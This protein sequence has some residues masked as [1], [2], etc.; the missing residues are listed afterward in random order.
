MPTIRIQGEEQ[1]LTVASDANLWRSLIAGG[2]AV[3]AP[4]G[5]RGTCGKCLVQVL[6][7]ELPAGEH[8]RRHLS[9]AQ[10]ADGWRLSCTARVHSDCTVAVPA[11]S[12]QEEIVAA[13]ADAWGPVVP[14]SGIDCSACSLSAASLSDQRPDLQRLQEALGRPLRCG[15][16]AL[17]AL[18]PVRAGGDLRVV[19]RG[20][21]LLAVCAGTQQALGITC[22]LGTTTIVVALFD[23]DSGEQLAQASTANPQG[24]FGADVVSRMGHA[25]S[26]AD[27][28]GQLRRLVV[29]RIQELI[30]GLCAE[31]DLAAGQ[32]VDLV[33]AGNTAMQ[34]LL[35]GLDCS[36]LATAPFVPVTGAGVDL[37]AGTLG[38]ACAPGARLR[39][40]PVI[41]AFVGGDI[42]GGLLARRLD[43][44]AGTQLFIDIGTNGEIVLVRDG[45]L[46]ATA[47]AAGPAFEGAG[48]SCGMR[49]RSGA[50]DRVR[51]ADGALQV[52]VIGGGPAIGICGTGLLE[53]VACL[54]DA[55]LCDETGLILDDDELPVACPAG[56]RSCLVEGEH[57]SAV[58]LAERADGSPVLLTQRDLRQVQLAKAA[59]AAGI[60]V[61]L[62]RSEVAAAD[63]DGIVLAG[64]FGFHLDVAAARRIGLL[65][66]DVRAEQ[67]IA[68]GNTSLAGARLCLLRQDCHERAERLARSATVIEL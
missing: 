36:G 27:L 22:D 54:L 42:V 59:I 11:E 18:A 43:E 8:D 1:S 10:L 61:L 37:P 66:A 67:V 6:D 41:A 58:R 9:Q 4:C 13:Y 23:L 49:A 39:V 25:I 47:T 30:D 46:V 60:G 26:D 19:H 17:H 53:A 55:G 34:H 57:G 14:A 45:R 28:A 40:L 64:G 48:I 2:L 20:D 62:E 50:I 16:G 29:D 24:R 12:R 31:R 63:I 32:V 44:A 15:P 51:L 33:V 52:G 38:F 5:G 3:A 65:P 21:E 56:L 7:G 35:L 68:V